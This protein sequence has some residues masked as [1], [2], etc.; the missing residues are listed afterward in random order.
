[1]QILAWDH[2]RPGVLLEANRGRLWIVPYTPN[3]IRVRYTLAAE[4]SS[5][6][7][8][9]VTAVPCPD[10]AV[11]VEDSA[12]TVD[13]LTEALRL[14]ITKSTGA[15]SFYD[16]DGRLLV[17]E[18]SSGGKLLEPTDVYKPKVGG[19]GTETVMEPT[20]DGMRATAEDAPLMFDRHAYH[21]KLSFE[22]APTEALYG[23]G[24]HE[25]GRLNWRGTHQ[26]LYQQNT[27]VAV[28]VLVSTAGYAVLV[29]TYSLATF[30]D[31]QYGSYLWTDVDDELDYYVLYGPEFD[32]LVGGL[33]FLSGR[34]TML[35]KWA[36][37]YWQ[38]KERYSSQEELLDIARE[39]RR[40]EIPLDVVVQDWR[41]WPEG[42]W[43]QK[44]FDPARYP[45]PSALTGQLHEL[46]VRLVVSIWPNLGGDGPNQRELLT[47]GRMLSDGSTYDAFS[48]E[49]RAMYW[50][51]MNEGL[52]RY[53]VD[54]WWADSTEPFCADWTGAFKPEP[55]ARLRMNVEQT[56]RYL[57]PEYINAY[58]LL[59]SQGIYE[60][61]RSVTGNKRVANLT[62][63][64]YLG[65]QRYGTITWSGDIAAN[66]S[67]MRN[68]IAAGLN[69]CVTGLP[70]WTL[71]V[72]AFFVAKRP[73]HWFWSGDFNDGC[74]DLG[75]RELYA[76]W[77]QWATF[78]PVMRAHGTDTPREVWRFGNP[79][80]PFYEVLVR[81]IRLRYRL[82]P[83]V[84]SVA[85]W[86]TLSSYTMLRLMAFDFRT[87]PRTANIDDQYLFG[88]A[89]LVNPV[90]HPMYYGPGSIPLSGVDERRPVYL[91][92]GANW[93]D[94]WTGKRWTG[95][96][97]VDANA[98]LDVLPIFVR[99]GSIVPLAPVHPHA[100]LPA[101]GVLEIRV[102]P[103]ASASFTLYEDAGDGYGYERGEYSTITITWDD[104]AGAIVFQA[105][106]GQYPGMAPTRAFRVIVVG[107]GHGV[108]VGSD[109]E[110]AVKVTYGGE[111]LRIP[112]P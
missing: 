10:T 59:H 112:L 21:T 57:D 46:G 42:L 84:Y 64:A 25:E 80:E 24:S 22:W 16:R 101:D 81:F 35:P 97:T 47:A 58:S 99:E 19:A 1:M 39:Y 53:G 89:F 2:G 20:V 60:G 76:R 72:G 92:A 17:R 44:S 108:G 103:G 38:S 83:Y 62:R 91:P 109:E 102:Y 105:R 55:E 54:G 18:P 52:F 6:A 110:P 78:L 63:S 85:A 41:S 95:G 15:F 56:K 45:D 86:A 3:I 106:Q 8:L 87:D 94:F 27:K 34:P 26:Y 93:V 66:W 68:Q 73:D 30:H 48:A 67:T 75:Y 28:P 74:N 111:A 50:R 79:G 14:E 49:A 9:T 40:R 29:D 43:G 65:Q 51:Q 96:Q 23:L 7:S 36:F 77:M 90:T 104:P 11:T 5:A 33:H 32:Q 37:G 107:E 71:D 88:P 13:I 4:F 70:F 69:F 98:P 12:E 100:G 31:D 82:L 61:Q